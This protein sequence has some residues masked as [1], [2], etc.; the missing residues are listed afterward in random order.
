MEPK[1]FIRSAFNYD[2]KKASQNSKIYITQISKTQQNQKEDADINVIVKRFGLTG[3]LPTNVRVPQYGDYTS[4]TNYQ[5]ALNQVIAAE[6][7][8]MQMPAEIRERFQ[9]DAG[10][11][12]EFFSDEKNRAEG[13]RLGLVLPKAPNPVVETTIEQKAAQAAEKTTKKVEP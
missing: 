11:F 6:T 1:I 7:A 10:Q 4:V 13:E 2:R 8:F 5:D 3:Q 9:N 12:V